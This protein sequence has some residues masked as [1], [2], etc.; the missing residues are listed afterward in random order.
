M[1]FVKKNLKWIT[2]LIVVVLVVGLGGLKYVL[3]KNE[4]Y[5]MVE[6]ELVIKDNLDEKEEEIKDIEVIESFYVDIKGAVFHPG[7]YEV[8]SGQKVI[9]VV[10]LAGGFTDEAD[11]SLINLAKEVSSEMVIIIYTVDE[12]KEALAGNDIFKIVDNSCVCPDIKNDACIYT[13]VTSNTG[14]NGTNS[15]SGTS[16]AG[17]VNLNTATAEELESLPGIGAS[18]AQA[19]IKYREEVG[20]F[21]KIEDLMEVTGI[22]E[23]LYE[24]VKEY[25]TV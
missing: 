17:K 22:G 24:K 21:S 5:D 7:V 4:K 13:D 1:R 16:Y 25:I 2:I 18:K 14:E 12:V 20:A 6:E 9:D 19:I 23:A 10:N 3:L 15:N 11:T 8:V